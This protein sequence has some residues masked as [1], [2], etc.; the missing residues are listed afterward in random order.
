MDGFC[1]NL[2]CTKCNKY[3]GVNSEG[4]CENCQITNCALCSTD[5]TVC[6]KC[7]TDSKPN[8]TKTECILHC[9]INC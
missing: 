1:E 9:S 6:N 8:D 3:F 5:F 4:S 7:D 2:K